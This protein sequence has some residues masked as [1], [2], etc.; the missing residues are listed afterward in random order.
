MV[1]FERAGDLKPESVHIKGMFFGDPGSGK[2]WAASTAPDCLVLLTEQN[3]LTSIRNSN[4]D[5]YVV[6]CPDIHAVRKY[7]TMAHK[8][9]LKEHG[10]RT[11]VIDS[12]TEVQRLFKD[13]ILAAK[14]SRDSLFTLQDWGIL[15]EK[16]RMFMRALRVVPYHVICTALAQT[17]IEESTGV[18]YVLPCFEGKK[19]PAEVGQYFNFVGYMAKKS[20]VGEDGEQQ[21][22]HRALLSGGER[23]MTKPVHPLE[24]VLEVDLSTWFDR[25]INSI[26]EKPKTTKAKAKK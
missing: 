3:G 2:T 25:I 24:G 17:M 12:L 10:I 19:V 13:E 15:N 9:Q 1:A 23:Y 14:G 21:V 5:A 20:V 16:M 11:I 7:M 8:D 4:R 22:L 6:H 26:S 18:R